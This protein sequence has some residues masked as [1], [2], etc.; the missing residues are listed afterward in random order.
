MSL[1]PQIRNRIETLLAS[2]RVVLFMKGNRQ[3]PACGFSAAA[4][5]RLDDIID[6]YATFDVLGDEAMRQ[7]IKDYGNWPTIPQLYVGGELVGGSDIIQGMHDSGELHA[8]LG[9]EAPDR[10]PPE[11]SI[12]DRAV[13][14]I[15]QALADNENTNLLLAVDA[16][17]QP[18]FQML[19]KLNGSE[20]VAQS[21]GLDVYFDLASAQRAR[22]ASIDWVKSGHG[23][24]L[25]IHLPLGPQPI[26]SLDVQQLRERMTAG[27]ITVI[28]V[29]PLSDREF[30]PFADA[31]VLDDANH[32]KLTALP[33][34]TALAF[35]CHHGNSS[36]QAAEYF[37]GQGFKSLWNVEGGVDAWAREVDPSFP[38]Y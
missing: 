22:G 14:V 13:E 6:D 29:R 26:R 32:A 2:Q 23:E 3:A 11:I 4:I 10:T 5:G 37:R 17:F 12:S 9:A 15:R 20:I 19:E 16:K 36:R 25:S 18:Q 38:R 27:D 35:L 1:N 31:Q 34:D 24:G 21:N 30:A 28:D 33:K 7:G 8:L